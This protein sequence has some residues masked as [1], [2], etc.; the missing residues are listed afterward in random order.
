MLRV[1]DPTT[2]NFTD[3][4]IVSSYDLQKTRPWQ[5]DRKYFDVPCNITANFYC[6]LYLHDDFY[7]IN[8]TTFTA[9]SSKLIGNTS[10]PNWIYFRILLSSS[11]L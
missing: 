9:V 11:T 6:S 1:Y 3:I 4:G 2:I 7:R 8:K 5:I 10:N